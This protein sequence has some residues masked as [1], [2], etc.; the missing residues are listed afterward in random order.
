MAKFDATEANLTGDGRPRPKP[1][2]APLTNSDVD[3][4]VRKKMD[5]ETHHSVARDPPRY[6]YDSIC[7]RSAT[8]FDQVTTW[9]LSFVVLFCHRIVTQR[10]S[11]W[12]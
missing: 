12:R 4:I 6:E 11:T 3:R 8:A 5:W 7:R 9:G 10:F 2:F 1:R